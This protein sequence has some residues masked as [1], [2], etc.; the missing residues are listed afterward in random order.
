MRHRSVEATLAAILVTWTGV[1][2]VAYYAIHK[3][4]APANVLATGETAAGLAGAG[5][6]VALG[7]GVGLLLLP[8]Q[9]LTPVERLVWAAALGLGVVSVVGLGLGAVGLLQRWLLWLL[10]TAGL[11][12][13]FRPL[14]RGLRAAWADPAWR[15]AGRFEVSVALFCGGTLVV[16]LGWALA[17][18]TA[19]DSLVYHLTG[20]KLYL[21]TGRVSHPVDLPYLGFPQLVEMLFAWGTGM[22]GER[23]AAPIHWFYGLLAVLGLVTAGR[24][25]LGEGSGWLASAVLLAAHSVVL[26]AGWPYV[27]LALLLY[28][29]LSFLSLARFCEPDPPSRRWLVLSGV[30]A[31]LALSTKYTALAILPALGLALVVSQVSD[32]GPVVRQL[33]LS[34]RNALVLCSVALLVWA[35]WLLKNSLLTGNPTYPFFLGGV[36]WDEWRA[37]WYDR[38]GTGLWFTAPWRLVTAPWDAT[39]WGVEGKEGYAAT[40]G[41]LFLA[42]LPLLVLTWRRLSPVQR[43][44]LRAALAFCGVLYGFWLWGAART[45]LLV[46]TRLLLPAS[47]LLALAVGAV[48]SEGASLPR[49][50]VDLR[51]IVRAIVL[52][53]LVLSLLDVGLDWVSQGPQGVLLGHEDRDAYLSR[54]LGWYYS[55]VQAVN[56]LP[57]EPKVLFLWEPRSYHCRVACLPDALLDRWLHSTHR[58]GHRASVISDAWRAE[59]ITHV[60]MHRTGYDAIL[61]AG[62]DPVAE[63]DQEALVE[64]LAGEMARVAEFGGAYELYAFP[65]ESRP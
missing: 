51:W 21:A 52:L 18:P 37:W 5:F 36:H 64:L 24:R 39:I 35:P 13:T 15:P 56:E 6:V 12:V 27:D 53:V 50:P 38:P 4:F 25:W 32:P 28:A 29:T 58:Y 49:R 47:G 48:L 43:R 63:A 20:P 8:R 11:A 45:A 42:L 17:P 34:I 10:T 3:P 30:F 14:W 55:A 1:V 40:I 62:F 7:A 61:A 26:L 9:D 54:R 31:G 2:V 22:V 41:P 59:G 60:L 23:G 57:G 16:A 19:W 65:E 44:W 46:Q 33:G